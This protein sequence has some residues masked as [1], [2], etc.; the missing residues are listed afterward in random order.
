MLLGLRRRLVVGRRGGNLARIGEG[1]LWADT[2]LRLAHIPSCGYGLGFGVVI[3]L[4]GG[5][6]WRP[7]WAQ[8]GRW[9]E[10]LRRRHVLG[11]G[12]ALRRQ[13]ACALAQWPAHGAGAPRLRKPFRLGGTAVGSGQGGA[14]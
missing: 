6:G 2:T 3:V 1:R 12:R 14:S 13:E 4:A 10:G 7:V 5:A 9:R 11:G 8:R